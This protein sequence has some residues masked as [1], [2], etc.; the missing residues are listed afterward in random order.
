MHGERRKVRTN[1]LFENKKRRENLDNL[2]VC[3][4]INVKSVIL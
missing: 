4:R 2:G 3:G 1:V